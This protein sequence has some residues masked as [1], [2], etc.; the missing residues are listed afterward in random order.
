MSSA[1][2]I[3]ELDNRIK[4]IISSLPANWEH[5]NEIKELVSAL[6]SKYITTKKSIISK[7]KKSH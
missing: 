3:S 6:R 7:Y 4:E 2:K 5:Y 1:E